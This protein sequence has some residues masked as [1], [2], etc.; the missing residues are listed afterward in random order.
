[1]SPKAASECCTALH[2]YI[3]KF[4]SDGAAVRSIGF[5]IIS[6]YLQLPKTEISI[7]VPV[8]LVSHSTSYISKNRRKYK[9]WHNCIYQI[10]YLRRKNSFSRHSLYLANCYYVWFRWFQKWWSWYRRWRKI[11]WNVAEYHVYQKIIWIWRIFQ[12]FI[13]S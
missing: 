9:R 6:F 8:G 12:I 10:F 5:F 4:C 11:D 7:F 1:M 13:K 3:C 2:C